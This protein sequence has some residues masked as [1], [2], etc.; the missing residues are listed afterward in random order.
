VDDAGTQRMLRSATTRT[1]QAWLEL[2]ASLRAANPAD[3]LAA[4]LHAPLAGV[5]IAVGQFAASVHQVYLGAGQAEARWLGTELERTPATVAK[6]LIAFDVLDEDAVSWAGRNRL[7]LIREVSAEVRQLI[8]A[9]LEEGARTGANPLDVA[10]M[11]RDSIG[12][13]EYQ[14]ERV[15]SYRRALESGDL[16]RALAAELGDGRY[17][18]SL[19]AAFDRGDAIPPARI[20]QM[21]A[22]YRANWIQ[23]RAETIARTQGLRAAHQGSEALFWQAVDRGTIEAQQIERRWLHHDRAG[24]RPGH[25]QMHGMT[26]GLG[27]AFETPDGVE[28]LYPCDPDAPPEET[29]QCTCAVATRLKPR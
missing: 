26:R 7:D 15:A 22:R 14:L 28:L 29:I 8:A 16:P 11:F 9:A 25:R 10:R 3:Q 27:E 2:I 13:T 19:Q 17:D 4:R 1:G 5:D 18:R 23:F 20:E 12:L 21:V 6:K 24:D